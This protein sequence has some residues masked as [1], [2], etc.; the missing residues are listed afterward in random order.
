MSVAA[1]RSATPSGSFT[2]RSI[3]ITRTSAYE[4]G[5][6]PQYA[7]RSPDLISVTPG[8]TASTTPAPSL[9][10]PVGIGSLYSP[11]R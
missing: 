10:S 8:P 9:P 1:V 7:T 5:A 11:L 2:S 4:P 3:G 6:P